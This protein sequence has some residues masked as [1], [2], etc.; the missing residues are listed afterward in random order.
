MRCLCS[1]HLAHWSNKRWISKV[2]SYFRRFF[3][4]SSYLSICTLALIENTY[5]ITF[6]PGTRYK[7]A[8]VGPGV[9]IL[10]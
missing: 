6:P 3:N 5:S 8:H 4:T 1:H 7:K 2:Y 10:V 9:N